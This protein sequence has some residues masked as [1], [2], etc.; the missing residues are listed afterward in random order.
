MRLVRWKPGH[1]EAILEAT[2][3]RRQEVSRQPH[4]AE[5]TLGFHRRDDAEPFELGDQEH[6]VEG[7]IVRNQDLPAK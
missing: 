2:T 3:C 6:G 4:G 1:P 7:Q 5:S